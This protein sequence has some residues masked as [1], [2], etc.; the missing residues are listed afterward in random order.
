MTMLNKS[1]IPFAALL[2]MCVSGK[3]QQ[4]VQILT[5]HSGDNHRHIKDD[6]LL[7]A[8]TVREGFCFLV[9]NKLQV[10]NSMNLFLN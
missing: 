10:H 3:C 6:T 9:L 7:S 1:F 8:R 4:P 5:T 2:L